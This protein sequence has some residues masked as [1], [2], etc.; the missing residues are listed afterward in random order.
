MV[1]TG[2]GIYLKTRDG[3]ARAL[4]GRSNPSCSTLRRQYASARTCGRNPAVKCLCSSPVLLVDAAP[5]PGLTSK[6]REETAMPH[7]LDSADPA[8]T[9]EQ[10]GGLGAFSLESEPTA[11]QTMTPRASA[12]ALPAKRPQFPRELAHLSHVYPTLQ[13]SYGRWLNSKN[14]VKRH[15]ATADVSTDTAAGRRPM[16]SGDR[17]GVRASVDHHPRGMR[18]VGGPLMDVPHRHRGS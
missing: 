12:R 7:R 15:P 17:T 2:K 8:K 6:A 13:P 4:S 11:L 16:I 1:S 10:R 9:M 14:F 3:V 5:W 18:P